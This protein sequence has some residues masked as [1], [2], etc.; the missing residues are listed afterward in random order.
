MCPAVKASLVRNQIQI[1]AILLFCFFSD[2]QNPRDSGSRRDDRPEAKQ[3]RPFCKLSLAQTS[4]ARCS[5]L[6]YFLFLIN[7]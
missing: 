3:F 2:S 7:K 6:P 1:L 4:L 5:S